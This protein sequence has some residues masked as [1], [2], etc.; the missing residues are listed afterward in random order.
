MTKKYM[1]LTPRFLSGS[2]AFCFILARSGS[3][4]RLCSW[5]SNNQSINQ[6]INLYYGTPEGSA[7]RNT[8]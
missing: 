3:T 7:C 4:C 6:S 8:Q 5:G 2:W 1:K